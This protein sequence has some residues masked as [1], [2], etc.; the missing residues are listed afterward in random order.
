MQNNAVPLQSAG[1]PPTVTTLYFEDQRLYTPADT[2][3]PRQHDRH[4]TADIFSGIFLNENVLP[5][6]ITDPKGPVDYKTA[7]VY[8]TGAYMRHSVL[9]FSNYCDKT[10]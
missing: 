3:R 8:F 2:L 4:F 1:S 10:E 5:L 6:K 9:I 7:L